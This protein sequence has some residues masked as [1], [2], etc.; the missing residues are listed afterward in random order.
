[1]C[2]SCYLEGLFSTKTLLHVINTIKLPNERGLCFCLG[3]HPNQ[4]SWNELRASK[5]DPSELGLFNLQKRQQKANL[6]TAVEMSVAASLG[7]VQ[8]G[9]VSHNISS[10]TPIWTRLPAQFV[11]VSVWR[12]SFESE[13]SYCLC[14]L[15]QG[16]AISIPVLCNSELEPQQQPEIEIPPTVLE[17]QVNPMAVTQP[18]MAPSF[19]QILLASLK[20]KSSLL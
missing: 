1:M 3:K 8:G 5:G 18:K 19:G 7:K 14:L 15:G 9:F 10:L 13:E 17:S 6:I 12:A 16:C 2:L 20:Q 4:T 11:M